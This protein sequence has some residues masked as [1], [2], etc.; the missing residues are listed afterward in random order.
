MSLDFDLTTFLHKAIILHFPYLHVNVTARVKSFWVSFWEWGTEEWWWGWN[1]YHIKNIVSLYFSLTLWNEYHP[2]NTV[3]LGPTSRM[4]G[5]C[6]WEGKRNMKIGILQSLKS[7]FKVQLRSKIQNMKE[8]CS[9]FVGI[10]TT[11]KCVS[12]MR[13]IS[14]QL[15][16]VQV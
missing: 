5:G 12:W 10:L 4:A 2:R 6:N 9:G 16:S 11:F 15:A 8:E 7:E 13:N 1:E 14:V 3:S